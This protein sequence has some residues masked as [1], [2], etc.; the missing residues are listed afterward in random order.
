[1]A[2]LA[3]GDA[4]CVDYVRT[5]MEKEPQT[6]AQTRAQIMDPSAAPIVPRTSKTPEERDAETMEHARGLMME[7]DEENEN[8]DEQEV[9]DK[10]KTERGPIFWEPL[11]KVTTDNENEWRKTI[12]Y[13]VNGAYLLWRTTHSSTKDRVLEQKFRLYL[14]AHIPLMNYLD[15]CGGDDSV[16]DEFHLLCLYGRGLGPSRYSVDASSV[17]VTRTY[18]KR[19]P[20]PLEVL[21]IGGGL[22]DPE[23]VPES[24]RETWIVS[25]ESEWNPFPACETEPAKHTLYRSVVHVL[26]QCVRAIRDPTTPADRVDALWAYYASWTDLFMCCLAAN[27]A[28]DE[29]LLLPPGTERGRAGDLQY[30]QDR[31]CPWA[32]YGHGKVDTRAFHAGDLPNLY[33]VLTS[34]PLRGEQSTPPFAMGKIYQKSLPFA[35]QRRHLIK[36]VVKCIRQDEAFWRVFSKLAWVFLANLYPG[37]LRTSSELC[38]LGMRDLV[39]IRELVDSP[40]LLIG[41]MNPTNKAFKNGG[42]L[43][44]FTIFRMHIL[45]MASFNE[46]YARHARACIDW[47]YFKRDVL[48]LASIVRS[49]SLFAADPFAQARA[50]LSKTVKSPHSRVHRLRRRS[51]AV[52][53]MEHFNDT[54]EKTILKDKQ[55]HTKDR[56]K[57]KRILDGDDAIASFYLETTIGACCRANDSSSSITTE[58]VQQAYELAVA[59]CAFYERALNMRYKSAIVNALIR[60]APEQRLTRDAFAM[61]TLPEYGGATEQCVVLLCE[62]CTVYSEKAVPKEFRQRIDRFV[63]SDFMAACYYLNIVALLEKIDF[64]PLDADTIERT[65]VA[66]RERRHTPGIYDVSVALCCE[67]VCTLMGTGKHGDEKVAY[68]VEK[69]AYVCTHGKN[70]HL[71]HSGD[72]DGGDG[73]DGEDEEGDGDGEED[74]GGWSD[75]DDDEE[76]D[77]NPNHHHRAEQLLAHTNR[78]LDFNIDTD[79]IAD[80][81][82]MHG[83]GTKRSR[84]MEER[85]AVRNERKAFSKIPCGQPVLTFSLYGR[86]LVW[87]NRRESKAQIMFCPDCGSLHVYTIL[88]Y[89]HGTAPGRYRC[90]ECARKETLPIHHECAFCHRAA[91]GQVTEET[92]LAVLDPLEGEEGVRVWLYFCK[93]H[94]RIARYYTGSLT[95]RDLWK[96]IRKV[97]EQRQANYARGIYHK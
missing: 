20:T 8:E 14:E 61:L 76:D 75:D 4:T 88:N 17:V 31:A 16:V 44:V 28:D 54:L 51:M 97:V 56:A 30:S 33:H 65:E 69:C 15:Q 45:Y 40:D 46:Q 74:G 55:S 59:A 19:K 13:R 29:F 49:H 58:L 21:G 53:L 25:G 60:L 57:L 32:L 42:P 93:S 9:D 12:F 86:A 48:S 91:A 63:I 79:L 47:D 43:V 7:E 5:V 1:V 62:L 64:V 92:R 50:Q 36:L 39:R 68:D 18:H 90:T 37:E 89:V 23:R 94:W 73:G 85:K 95:K 2:I 83:R 66:M 70:M 77:T 35:C 3:R 22:D 96:H 72:G 87:G 27:R 11:Q 26:N 52:T 81:V 41:A 71:D 84:V 80:A 10:Q 24:S 6:R 78:G 34:I 82:T 67:K 38:A